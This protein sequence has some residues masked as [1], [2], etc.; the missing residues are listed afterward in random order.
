M[1]GDNANVYI[2]AKGQKAILK[3]SPHEIPE[4]DEELTFY[5]PKDQ[6]YLFDG[7]TEKRI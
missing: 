1:L 7:E 2:D 6:I 3:V 5:L 4:M